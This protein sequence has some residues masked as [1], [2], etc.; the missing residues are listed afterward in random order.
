MSTLVKVVKPGTNKNQLVEP[1]KI[2]FYRQFGWEPEQPIVVTAKPTKK[3]TV[4][5][6]PAV[7]EEVGTITSDKGEEE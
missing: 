5:P 1:D 7:E 4:E 6:E 2:D 3:K